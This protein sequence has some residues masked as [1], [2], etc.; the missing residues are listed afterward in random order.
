MAIKREKIP[1]IYV[2]G[3]GGKRGKEIRRWERVR[4]GRS[5]AEISDYGRKIESFVW[6]IRWRK[7]GPDRIGMKEE[8][9]K[10]RVFGRKVLFSPLFPPFFAPARENDMAW[11]RCHG[12]GMGFWSLCTVPDHDIPPWPMRGE[13]VAYIFFGFLSLFLPPNCC[14]GISRYRKSV[15]AERTDPPHS[16]THKATVVDFTYYGKC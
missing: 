2:S 12:H 5:T 6:L 4:S 1:E 16:R 10:T 11:D 7:C 14:E 15:L 13:H 8:L 9:K 3:G